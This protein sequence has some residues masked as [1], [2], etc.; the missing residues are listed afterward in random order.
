[1]TYTLYNAKYYFQELKQTFLIY[2]GGQFAIFHN[3]LNTIKKKTLYLVLNVLHHLK[4]FF[5][6]IVSI[7]T[8]FFTWTFFML[9]LECQVSSVVPKL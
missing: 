6:I 5:F 1:M 8:K 2:F 7:F 9:E 3:D 4:E